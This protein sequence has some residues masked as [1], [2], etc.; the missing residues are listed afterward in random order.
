[1]ALALVQSGKYIKLEKTLEGIRIVEY[2][3]ASCRERE[4]AAPISRQSLLAAVAQYAESFYSSMLQ[5][6]EAV[7]YS[8]EDT[9]SNDAMMAFLA[10][11]PPLEA[12][13]DRYVAIKS[14]VHQLGNYLDSQVESPT[15]QLP[16]LYEHVSQT[17][18][19]LSLA[20]EESFYALIESLHPLTV[21]C[22]ITSPQLF[23][24]QSTLEELYSIVKQQEIFTE[25]TVDC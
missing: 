14:E 11:H 22:E 23:S 25:G 8:E 18:S 20:T 15:P 13:Y 10:S 4:K 12:L 1:M 17:Y 24:P 19:N 16:Y 21:C 3:S 7:G 6:V 2:S 5:Q 9:V